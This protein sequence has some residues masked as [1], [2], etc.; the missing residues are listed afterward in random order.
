VTAA[1]LRVVGDDALAARVR[2]STWRPGQ[3]ANE[4]EPPLEAEGDSAAGEG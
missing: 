3:V 1:L 2:P 4:E